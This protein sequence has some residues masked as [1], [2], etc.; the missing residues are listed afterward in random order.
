MIVIGV[1]GPS[2]S[3]KSFVREA[4]CA[5]GIPVLDADAVYHGW[6]DRQTPCTQA[7]ARAFGKEIL[8]PSGGI[9]RKKLANVV[10][11]GGNTEKERLRLLNGITHPYVLESCRCWLEEQNK[12]GKE[13]AVLDAPLLIES[14]LNQKCDHVIAVLAPEALRVSRIMARDG[15]TEAAAKSRIAAQKDDGFY[16]S[17][18]DFIFVNDGTGEAAERF[19][20]SLL[21]NLSIHPENKF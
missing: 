4:F 20:A 11:C 16:K 1:T 14:G 7:L 19:V 6:I 21:L 2:G 9:D 18:A 13:A 17:H 5:R 3:G 12:Q 8:S 15:L 10:F